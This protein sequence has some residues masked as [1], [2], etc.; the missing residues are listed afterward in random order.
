MAN[1]KMVVVEFCGPDERLLDERKGM[2]IAL[3]LYI[4]LMRFSYGTNVK[5]N[6]TAPI[7]AGANLLQATPHA[8]AVEIAE[9]V[10]KQWPVYVQFICQHKRAK[11]RSIGEII[12]RKEN[13]YLES[14]RDGQIS[15]KKNCFLWYKCQS[16]MALYESSF[17]HL[18]CFHP[19][20]K[21]IQLVKVDFEPG[22]FNSLFVELAKALNMVDDD[23][24]IDVD[25]VD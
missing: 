19:K 14:D 21:E 25:V 11:A 3:P 4:R 12:R 2:S 16:M 1:G 17:M 24:D 23:E 5:L 6:S 22:V 7:C 18:V 13:F 9:D 20:T 10:S 15:L 8:L